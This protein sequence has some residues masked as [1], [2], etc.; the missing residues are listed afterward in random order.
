MKIGNCL[1]SYIANATIE[2]PT[3]IMEGGASVLGQTISRHLA[4]IV[5]ILASWHS[6]RFESSLQ[7]F[8]FQIRRYIKRNVTLMHGSL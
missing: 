8:S 3:V 5:G 7:P 1:R 4:T 6:F 2:E